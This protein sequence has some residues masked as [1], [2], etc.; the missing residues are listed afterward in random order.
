LEPLGGPLGR[1]LKEEMRREYLVSKQV[2]KLRVEMLNIGC[3]FDWL[4]IGVSVDRGLESLMYSLRFF[5]KLFLVFF[6]V[7]DR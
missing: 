4:N 3:N 5:I 6:V 2:F 1:G 7:G